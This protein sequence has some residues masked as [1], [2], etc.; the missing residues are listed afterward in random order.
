MLFRICLPLDC[1]GLY[2]V[3]EVEDSKERKCVGW[4]MMTLDSMIMNCNLNLQAGGT[5]MTGGAT[6]TAT[7]PYS[8]FTNLTAEVFSDESLHNISEFSNAIKE[9]AAKFQSEVESFMQSVPVRQK[10]PQKKLG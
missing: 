1:N 3:R 9:K 10:D 4:K 7:F 2:I 8:V 5:G 6:Q